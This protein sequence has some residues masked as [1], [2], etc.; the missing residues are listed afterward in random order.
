MPLPP[1]TENPSDY[2][3]TEEQAERIWSK[4]RLTPAQLRDLDEELQ[5]RIL[6]R[7][8]FTDLPTK[9]QQYFS[10]AHLGDN[11]TIPDD[12][13]SKA[14]EQLH[15]LRAGLRAPRGRIGG[16]SAGP[17]TRPAGPLL[18]AFTAGLAPDNTGWKSLGPGNIG[19]RIRSI[20]IDPSNV[21]KI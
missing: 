6:L 19:G 11:L 5:K 7:I 9:R 12:A 16:L 13:Y 21:Q 1:G 20:I 18:E 14:T 8:Q 17:M 2:A 15:Q 3:L 10:L 4:Y